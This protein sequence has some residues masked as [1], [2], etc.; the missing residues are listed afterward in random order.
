MSEWSVSPVLP[1]LQ[2]ASRARLA[3]RLRDGC[4][5][6]RLWQVL[7]TRHAGDRLTG[8]NRDKC[9]GKPI[10][11]WNCADVR[12]IC[13]NV[14]ARNRLRLIA[15]RML[16][17]SD[18]A[19]SKDE[20]EAVRIVLEH[21]HEFNPRVFNLALWIVAHSCITEDL[22]A[23]SLYVFHKQLTRRVLG[24]SRWRI[25][26]RSSLIVEPPFCIVLLFLLFNIAD[27]PDWDQRDKL[28][29]L[30]ITLI[31]AK[32]GLYRLRRKRL[33]IETERACKLHGFLT[34]LA[35]IGNAESAGYA[36]LALKFPSTY[37][38]ALEVLSM[39]VEQMTV[40]DYG[41]VSRKSISYLRDAL[42]HAD[43][44]AALV[45]FKALHV[46]G[47]KNCISIIEKNAR[48][49]NSVAVSA[50]AELLLQALKKRTEQ[51]NNSATLLR[52]SAV[53]LQT[54]NDLLRA[55]SSAATIPPAQLLRA[56]TDEGTGDNNGGLS[57][58]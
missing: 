34:A 12:E 23:A 18:T 2:R 16:D 5:R 51:L 17:D 45:L 48:R 30:A 36:A 49:L 9:Q 13:G 58:R 47:D 15:E 19:L 37:C 10:S 44:E 8:M 21:E 6:F 40:K 46:V 22:K 26:L 29:I 42:D 55:A 35:S 54:G 41:T 4:S 56:V 25:R 24:M 14:H 32:F 20:I 57:N 11:E 28:I 3:R 50:E 7:D 53:I 43:D 38:G 33:Q 31:V 1:M 52:S 27:I 39:L